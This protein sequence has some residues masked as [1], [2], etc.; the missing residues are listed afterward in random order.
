MKVREKT[1]DRILV[2]TA[3]LQTAI[4]DNLTQT[5]TVKEH[6]NNKNMLLALLGGL[7]S[8]VLTLSSSWNSLGILLIIVFIIISAAYLAGSLWFL[9]KLIHSVQLLKTHKKRDLY[10]V[11]N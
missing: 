3:F 11:K 7:T 10:I 5:K 1:P 9:N 8:C 6:E 2:N 4:S